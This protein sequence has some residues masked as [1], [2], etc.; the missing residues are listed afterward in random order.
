M[1][2]ENRKNETIEREH[3]YFC[4]WAKWE[5][6]CGHAMQTICYSEEVSESD[7]RIQSR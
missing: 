5:E 7:T 3:L 6:K 1:L 4:L 2:K